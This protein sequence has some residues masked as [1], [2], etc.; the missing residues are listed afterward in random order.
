MLEVSLNALIPVLFCH[1]KRKLISL[2]PRGL[3]VHLRVLIVDE[4]NGNEGRGLHG[5]AALASEWPDILSIQ[6]IRL[7]DS[8]SSLLETHE[9]KNDVYRQWEI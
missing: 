1:L 4:R 2:L 9:A 6:N 7:Q 3:Q 8:D 5:E